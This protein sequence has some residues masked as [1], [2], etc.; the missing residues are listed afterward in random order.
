MLDPGERLVET[1]APVAD[2]IPDTAGADHKVLI[3]TI[4]EVILVDMKVAVGTCEN[5]TRE[6]DEPPPIA[7]SVGSWEVEDEGRLPREVYASE[8]TLDL[9]LLEMRA[10][11]LTDV[12]V[13]LAGVSLGSKTE[14]AVSNRTPN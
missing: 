7:L 12:A 2:D 4:A 6:L 10:D 8:V 1:P 9:V 5:E 14:E 11:T 13:A 3:L